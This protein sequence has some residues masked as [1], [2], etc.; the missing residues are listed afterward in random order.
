MQQVFLLPSH[1]L[2][3]APRLLPGPASFL[4]DPI[5]LRVFSFSCV[6]QTQAS[7]TGLRQTGVSW[8]ILEWGPTC[9]SFIFAAKRGGSV[10][11]N[12][13]CPEEAGPLLCGAHGMPWRQSRPNPKGQEQRLVLDQDLGSELRTFRGE[14]PCWVPAQAWDV[15]AL[16]PPAR[17]GRVMTKWVR[18]PQP[19]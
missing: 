14:P 11:G 10:I 13:T 5:P 1:V 2:L 3:S 15:V 18:D 12:L 6:L 4:E 19:A 17:R 9:G 16:I 7:C 8:P